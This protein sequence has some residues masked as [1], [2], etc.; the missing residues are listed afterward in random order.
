MAYCA[1]ADIEAIFGVANVARWS[2]L[3]NT[4]S[5]ADASRIAAA[6]ADADAAIDLRFRGSKYA[7]PVVATTTDGVALLT[8]IAARLA[9]A[10]LYSHRGINDADKGAPAADLVIA[11]RDWATKQIRLVLTGAI[12][13]EANAATGYHPTCPVV[14]G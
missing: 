8:A 11:Q 4:S 5:A 9:G 14:C 6:I 7:V 12:Q 1:R 2:N 10:W 13:L 3:D